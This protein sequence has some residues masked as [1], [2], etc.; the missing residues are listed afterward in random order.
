MLRGRSSSC[1]TVDVLEFLAFIFITGILPV[2]INK[3]TEKHFHWV[4]PHLRVVWTA[5]FAFFS[6]YLLWKP[7]S[8]EVTMELNRRL[9]GTLGYLLCAVCGAMLLC[10]YWW[11][12]GRM[13]HLAPR[14]SLQLAF[15]GSPAMTDARKKMI[16][17]EF[18]AIQNYLVE[19]GYA[20]VT[21]IAPI[22]IGSNLPTTTGGSSGA[23][24]GN[25]STP[26]G[27]S[28]IV[29]EKTADSSVEMRG[30]YLNYFFHRLFEVSKH[31]FTKQPNRLQTAL[32]FAQYYASSYADK[33]YLNDKWDVALWEMRGSFR[34]GFV[35]TLLFYASKRFDEDWGKEGG[36]GQEGSD[37]FDKWFTGRIHLALQALD[38]SATERVDRILT[39]NGIKGKGLPSD[40]SRAAH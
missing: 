33:Q 20:P 32:L 21:P 7:A 39:A 25:P 38:Y 10:G 26:Y 24:L 16:C 14:C 6:L 27:D 36:Y 40:V 3:T 23:I 17:E 34:S 2:V 12:A 19:I 11:L 35:D 31:E 8:L 18:E 4:V 13:V 30:L 22:Q 28:I 29:N 1:Y 9:G 37:E 15:S 5:I